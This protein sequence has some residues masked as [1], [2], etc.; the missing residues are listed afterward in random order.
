MNKKIAI[1][2]LKTSINLNPNVMKKAFKSKQHTRVRRYEL[3]IR[4]P[5][6]C[7]LQRKKSK[8]DMTKV[9]KLRATYK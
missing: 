6:Y 5:Q 4:S 3:I 2:I 1:K 8:N 9:M 7:N